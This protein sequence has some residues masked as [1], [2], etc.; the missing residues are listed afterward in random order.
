MTCRRGLLILGVLI[1]GASVSH[2]QHSLLKFQTG[3][4][5]YELAGPPCLS[6]H[7]V[8]TTSHDGML[9]FT[10]TC[11]DGRAI[12]RGPQHLIQVDSPHSAAPKTSCDVSKRIG[13]TGLNEC[14][15]QARY[16]R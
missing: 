16:P 9:W 8:A 14:Q 10:W 3:Y 12:V 1:V 15:W 4:V 6:T 5:D 11:V 7:P 13:V 2:A